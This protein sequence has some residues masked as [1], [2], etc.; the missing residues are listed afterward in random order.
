MRHIILISF[1]S[2]VNLFIDISTFFTIKWWRFFDF[3][4]SQVNWKY[5]ICLHCFF[6]SCFILP[7]LILFTMPEFSQT[8][9]G[10]P[11]IYHGKMGARWARDGRKR[12]RGI[13]QLF[14]RQGSLRQ[15]SKREIFY[16]IF[17]FSLSN[18]G[19]SSFQSP[20]LHSL[21]STIN[22]FFYNRYLLH[23][24]DRL[25]PFLLFWN[26]AN[27]LSSQFIEHVK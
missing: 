6:P 24:I 19:M 16:I 10:W 25:N 22:V 18:V 13:L 4:F 20:F 8:G 3:R 17:L 7:L 5:F 21:R 11:F 26:K 9:Q 1:P 14:S 27:A 12:S 23:E 15:T 2:T